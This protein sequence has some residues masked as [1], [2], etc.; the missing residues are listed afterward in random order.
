MILAVPLAWLQ[1]TYEKSRLLVAIAGIT[2]AVI[3]MFMQIGFQDALFRSAVRLQSNLIGDVVLIS[4]QSTNLVGMRN[5]SRRRLYQTLGI[6]GVE[7]VSP[8]Y[9]GLA[10]WKIQ[11]STA[12]Q[13]R[14]ILVLGAD[15]DRNVFKLAGLNPDNLAQMR[16]QDVV[17][18]DRTSRAEFGPIVAECGTSNLPT[19][20]SC[21]NP[22]YREVA[23]R[24][25][26]VGGLFTLGSSFAADGAII[27]SGTNF[28]RIFDSRREGLI[29][30]GLI[31]LEA[32]VSPY[33]IMAQIV[34]LM[35]GDQVILTKHSLRVDNQR[36]RP[37][38]DDSDKVMTVSYTH[39][40][41]PTKA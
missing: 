17:L 22:V 14:N 32:G 35:Q 2:F 15:P 9:I 40:T 20:Y 12:G 23:N 37:V 10:A 39:L 13:T 34:N 30:V 18:F 41:L 6:K 19:D 28:L 33:A 21:P 24:R 26:R 7:S 11:E 4:P 3:L 29:N 5:F 36:V 38:A 16:Q 31:K 25:L 27:T 1:L 8:L